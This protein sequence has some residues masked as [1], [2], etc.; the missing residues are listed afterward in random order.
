MSES[1]LDK[2]LFSAHSEIEP[3]VSSFGPGE[4]TVFKGKTVELP[5]AEYYEN[6][7]NNFLNQYKNF[8][9][10][11]K[12]NFLTDSIREKFM[13][14]KNNFRETDE[15]A[16]KS[17]EIALE[18]LRFQSKN[19]KN[20]ISSEFAYET[21]KKY[22]SE[23]ILANSKTAFLCETA[24]IDLSNS[25]LPHDYKSLLLSLQFDII[26]DNREMPTELFCS[27]F[28]MFPL[29]KRNQIITEISQLLRNDLAVPA[30]HVLS[31]IASEKEIEPLLARLSQ[32]MNIE[33]DLESYDG[34]QYMYFCENIF[35]DSFLDP[36]IDIPKEEAEYD[37]LQHDILYHLNCDRL[38]ETKIPNTITDYIQML[39]TGNVYEATEF[40]NIM[41]SDHSRLSDYPRDTAI[42]ALRLRFARCHKLIRQLYKSS[43]FLYK[44]NKDKYF[45]LFLHMLSTTTAH[46]LET[47]MN[48]CDYDAV[49]ENAMELMVSYLDSKVK[50]VSILQT[51]YEQSDDESVL[52]AKELV[53]KQQPNCTEGAHKSFV[54]TLEI[55]AQCLEESAILL[56]TLHEIYIDNASKFPYSFVY[57][58]S[59]EQ[60]MSTDSSYSP[61]AKI[62]E[63]S[64]GIGR[65]AYIIQELPHVVKEICETMSIP[66]TIY[67]SYVELAILKEL[68]KEIKLYPVKALDSSLVVTGIAI[69]SD[70]N[71]EALFTFPLITS[72]KYISDIVESFEPK[73]RYDAAMKIRQIRK[74]CVKLIRFLYKQSYL[75]HAIDAQLSKGHNPVSLLNQIEWSISKDNIDAQ[76]GRIARLFEAQRRYIITLKAAARYNSYEN[77]AN[78]VTQMFQGQGVFLTDQKPEKPG[79]LNTSQSLVSMKD[80][81][82]LLFYRVEDPND[83]R[84]PFDPYEYKD[85]ELEE[86][87]N[88]VEEI[89]IKSEIAEI[90]KLEKGIFAKITSPEPFHI[91]RVNGE[92]IM[93]NGIINYLV[94]PAVAD[95]LVLR[96]SIADLR[97]LLHFVAAR[98][99]LLHQSLFRNTIFKSR[100]RLIE[101]LATRTAVADMGVFS[102]IDK[103]VSSIEDAKKAENLAKISY[104]VVVYNELSF[105]AGMA[106]IIDECSDL[107]SHKDVLPLF[108]QYLLTTEDD[109]YTGK[110][111]VTERYIPPYLFRF[112]RIINE[113]A[114]PILTNIITIVKSRADESATGLPFNEIPSVS[115]NYLLTY[116]RALVAKYALFRL[117]QGT[118][119]QDLTPYESIREIKPE[120]YKLGKDDYAKT[121]ESDANRRTAK[122]GTQANE[123]LFYS[124]LLDVTL[125]RIKPRVESQIITNL[126]TEIDLLKQ[127]VNSPFA[128]TPSTL[129]PE[130]YSKKVRGNIRSTPFIPSPIDVEKQFSVEQKYITLRFMRAVAEATDRE[131][132]DEHGFFVMDAE[133]LEKALIKLSPKISY[134]FD[135]STECV[136]NTW[137]S[138]M[139]NIET[140]VDKTKEF[141]KILRVFENTIHSRFSDEL[142]LGTKERLEPQLM[143]LNTLRDIERSQQRANK[144]FVKVYTEEV[145][146]EFE[147]LSSDLESEV[148]MR[149]AKYVDSRR[150]YYNAIMSTLGKAKGKDYN[151]AIDIKP[152]FKRSQYKELFA[153]DG[154]PISQQLKLQQKL[155]EDQKQNQNAQEQ[156]APQNTAENQNNT[157][158]S[159]QT[160]QEENSQQKEQTEKTPKEDNQNSI[161]IESNSNK[162]AENQENPNADAANAE[163][164]NQNTELTNSALNEEKPV[165]VPK[166]KTPENNESNQESDETNEQKNAEQ[167]HEENKSLNEQ[168]QETVEQKESQEESNDQEEQ[169]NTEENHEENKQPNEQNQET[170]E[171]KEPQ[172]E[173]NEQEEQ[174]DT[175]EAKQETPGQQTDNTQ[176]TAESQSETIK[177]STESQSNN[178]KETPSEPK[179]GE[180]SLKEVAPKIT[181]PVEPIPPKE[182]PEAFPSRRRPEPIESFPIRTPSKP[183]AGPRTIITTPRINFDITQKQNPQEEDEDAH[184]KQKLKFKAAMSVAKLP[185]INEFLAQ[186]RFQSPAPKGQTL[187]GSTESKS[188]EKS[189]PFQILPKTPI[190][191][192]DTSTTGTLVRTKSDPNLLQQ[193]GRLESEEVQINKLKVQA[194]K[195]RI[196][197]VF[198]T[199]AIRRKWSREIA[200]AELDRKLE[201]TLLWT[202]RR[203][204]EVRQRNMEAELHDGYVLLSQLSDKIDAMKIEHEEIHKE[205]I[206][207]IHSKEMMLARSERAHQELK[208]LNNDADI[209]VAE[210]IEQINAKQDELDM[211]IA[212]TDQIDQEIEYE[213]REP[214]R[215]ADKIKKRTLELKAKNTAAYAALA[216]EQTVQV[217]YQN[218]IE[219]NNRLKE[220][221]EELR[222]KILELGGK[223]QE[224]PKT[225]RVSVP[226][227]SL[228]MRKS[229]VKPLPVSARTSVG[230][231]RFKK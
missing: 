178:A 206:Q 128:E 168:N 231:L 135:K 82:S 125:E 56:E 142:S 104:D 4:C 85:K 126:Q 226:S 68:R 83:F 91:E 106:S 69:Q 189:T 200:K 86:I 71:A 120:D 49:F 11:Q 151:S 176:Q 34:Q 33:L 95:I 131:P 186:Q 188:P 110:F 63:A 7:I 229:I 117:Q 159:Q 24:V 198:L 17:L 53:L 99:R 101:G 47:S 180:P 102:F 13:K 84:S 6:L 136:V 118:K 30:T 46:A 36:L 139:A 196:S 97:Y 193:N 45:R 130:V 51:I 177:E 37:R 175:E 103:S 81:F 149:R 224:E 78:F 129:K 174:K 219:E 35:S 25:T 74:Y 57:S 185:K 228:S 64:P 187:Q 28:K 223:L 181:Q 192:V 216:K 42:C 155:E 157:E 167:N 93:D 183:K 115:A 153:E 227:I 41:L 138:Y 195:E 161:L 27:L 230:V 146:E 32:Q 163:T 59:K 204:A 132:K 105:T 8:T 197:R 60:K 38:E 55:Q 173:T 54:H 90:V 179:I 165:E 111:L 203:A 182:E 22:I 122:A 127:Q 76:M 152:I 10:V 221:N 150:N 160:Q 140:E 213:I 208:K 225:S 158:T 108:V 44:E 137:E 211:L 162:E 199:V 77:D 145:K 18:T 207:L 40:V 80:V 191:Q 70:E 156:N 141:D 171:Q 65:I 21:Y 100:K 220:E 75:E 164:N 205:N 147:E 144:K 124:N 88:V 123:T 184:L 143:K 9:T 172:K 1:E 166:V 96:E 58:T 109:T 202:G 116:L 107:L 50:L 73:D 214:M 67:N 48:G 43:E 52:K 148:N 210:L 29:V 19:M 209:S 218:I 217:N 66:H 119:Y 39:M 92:P 212:E 170:V 154:T 79:A 169:K 72:Y 14:D 26:K 12:I 112:S 194:L 134:L 5:E 133:R 121:I 87:A 15:T 61:P 222:Q 2:L 16:R 62:F 98:F 20:H 201:S 113:E 23:Q 215:Q 89:S 31:P 94:I 114:R 190:K 3:T